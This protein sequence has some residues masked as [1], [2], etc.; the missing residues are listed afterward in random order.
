LNL[1]GGALAAEWIQYDQGARFAT[2]EDSMSAPAAVLDRFPRQDT[3]QSIRAVAILGRRS[4]GFVERRGIDAVN[5]EEDIPLG[6]EVEVALGWGLGLFN[7][8]KDAT[9]NVGML[10]GGEY[11]SLL[12]GMR[13]VGEARRNREAK[14]TDSEWTDILAQ[15]DAWTY[16]RPSRDSRHTVVAAVAAIGGWQTTTPF[17][18]TL[19][20]HA[21]LRGYQEHV[22]PGEQRVVAALE[23]RRYLPWSWVKL[24]EVGT[25]LFANAGRVWRGHD[26]FG[27]DSGYQIAVGGGLRHAFPAGSRRTYRLDIAIPVAGDVPGKRVA[28][29]AGVGQAIGISALRHDSQVRR[30]ARRPLATSLLS[31]P[32]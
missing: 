7:T 22:F 32:R 26:P 9:I 14:G 24:G 19:G 5:A 30:S 4:I 3:I 10:T 17:Q 31:L 18:A 2:P 1:I 15:L 16:W 11:R 27:V 25:A 8:D 28:I 6:T 23:H 29:T 20:R 13:I 21:G 12:G